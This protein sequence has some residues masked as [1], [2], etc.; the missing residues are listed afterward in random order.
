M[1]DLIIPFAI[2]PLNKGD[3]VTE[4]AILQEHGITFKQI[5]KI[6]DDGSEQRAYIIPAREA[7]KQL[8]IKTLAREHK[9][10]TVFF[11]RN[12]QSV[13]GHN[14]ATGQDTE[15]GDWKGVSGEYASRKGGYFDHI[16]HRYYVV[17]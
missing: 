11:V 1:R 10:P 17:E 14:I 3:V 16:H 5:S 9:V 15:I 8:V 13:Y 4:Q 12:D 7:E 2:L 6:T